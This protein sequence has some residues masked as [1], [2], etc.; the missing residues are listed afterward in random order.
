MV[1]DVRH[2]G[3]WVG[4]L[5]ADKLGK[6]SERING[7]WGMEVLLCIAIQIRRSWHCQACK[8]ATT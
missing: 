7:S 2:S 6:G 3:G 1:R 8:L 5:G 4:S